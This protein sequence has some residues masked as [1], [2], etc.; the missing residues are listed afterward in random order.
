[1]PKNR[2]PFYWLERVF[3]SLHSYTWDDYLQL[4]ETRE[5]I[6]ATVAWLTSYRRRDNERV[7]DIGCGTGNYAL[8]LAEVGF[9]VVGIDFALGMLKKA[10]TKA[11]RLPQASVTFEQ[12]DFNR[13]LR[14][15][16]KSFDHVIC[17][18]ALQCV[19]SPPRFL[20]EIRRVLKPDGLFLVM[21][22]DSS[23]TAALKKKLKTTLPRLIFWKL[24]VLA[25]R[26]KR[27]RK[28]TRDELMVLLASVGFDVV[29]E[30]VYPGTIAL[31]GRARGR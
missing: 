11:A 14:F 20:R 31:M 25:S 28:Y 29:E 1:M 3:W 5:D 8:A 10:S 6:Q 26:S 7:L 30:R 13:D 19:A 22:V 21:A 23:Q 12:A 17:I 18:H 4:P 24:K 2:R 15:P 16:A 9:D 27:A